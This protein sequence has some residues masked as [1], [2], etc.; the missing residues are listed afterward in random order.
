MSRNS[1]GVYSLPG[2][3]N[4]VVSG[5]TITSTWANTTLDDIAAELTNSLDRSGRGSMSAPL[6]FADGAVG[7]PSITFGNDSA[8]G[9][10][11]PGAATIALSVGG[12]EIYRVQ[13]SAGALASSAHTPIF[14]TPVVVGGTGTDNLAWF[15]IIVSGAGTTSQTVFAPDAIPGGIA[16][17]LW[18][19]D[20]LGV[21]LAANVVAPNAN[22]VKFAS[23]GRQTAVDGVAATLE[24]GSIT[25]AAGP[26]ACS[27]NTTSDYRLKTEVREIPNGL[28]AMQ[29]G[30]LRP[31]SYNWKDVPDGKQL[32][33]FIAHEVQ[34]I[35]PQAVTGEKDGPTIQQMDASHLI[36]LLTAALQGALERIKVLED[37]LLG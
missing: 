10:Y 6:K 16:Q 29:I 3:V 8:T 25:S 17:T 19:R 11:R 4:P 28:A 21:P 5:T 20:Y 35:C 13:T 32:I 14:K 18:A 22:G 1:S 33:G 26:G 2:S 37:K 15:H 12:V 7:A 36:P 31:V 9:F 34:E 24:I 23:F 27:Y 30:L